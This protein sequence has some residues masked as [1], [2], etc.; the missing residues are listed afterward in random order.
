MQIAPEQGAFLTMLTRLIGRPARDRDRHVHRLLGAVHR[1]RACP[2][3]AGCSCCDVS[4]EWTSI[5]R[6]YWER[7]RRRPTASSCASR[8]RSTRCARCPA[9]PTFDLA[10]IDADKPNYA[11]LLR[12]AAAADAH[13]TALI[14]VDNVLWGGRVAS[15]TMPTTPTPPPSSD[16]TTTIAADAS[17]E[18]VMLPVG[19]GLSLIRPL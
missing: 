12:R 5:A 3:T 15:T 11:E 16:S 18:V 1:P 9:E 13:R 4:E 17:I 14:L 7:G 10:F 6:R 8:P 2:P 19:D